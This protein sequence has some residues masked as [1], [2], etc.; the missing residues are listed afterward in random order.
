MK[1]I[2]VKT[3]KMVEALSLNISTAN[4]E[5]L[6]S[7]LLVLESLSLRLQKQYTSVIA[8]L[9]KRKSEEAQTSLFED[10]EFANSV[11]S[12]SLTWETTPSYSV[13]RAGVL[14]DLGVSESS[15]KYG[16][17]V[18]TR[19]VFKEKQFVEAYKAGTLTSQEASHVTVTE[20]KQQRMAF[21]NENE[22]KEE[23]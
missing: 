15:T 1:K 8:E 23:K 20:V 9:T 21:G 17:F 12:V 18:E 10:E 2:N 16:N 11:N 22:N 19:P 13:D 5:E 3:L 4:K 14:A 6:A 7:A